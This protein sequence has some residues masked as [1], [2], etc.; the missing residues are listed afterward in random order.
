MSLRFEI[1]RSKES[2]Q[3]KTCLTNKYKY[4]G[5]NP[6]I[7][8][9]NSTISKNNLFKVLPQQDLEVTGD[10]SLCSLVFWMYMK[11]TNG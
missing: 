3:T 4:R 9:R 8:Q 10:A 7:E 6:Y 2:S 1:I 11:L 5:Q